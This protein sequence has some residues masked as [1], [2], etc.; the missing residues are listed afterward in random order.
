M[1][2][3]YIIPSELTTATPVELLALS[4]PV[5]EKTIFLKE[6][7][8]KVFFDFPTEWKTTL[9]D[10]LES[11]YNDAAKRYTFYITSF[12]GKKVL[13]YKQDML[14]YTFREYLI[15]LLKSVKSLT[16]Y[17]LNGVIVKKLIICLP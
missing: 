17:I 5:E 16:L 1:A 11:V 6:S 4:N 8:E 7:K 12:D 2:V 3:N 15:G 13:S 14:G 9:N 10:A